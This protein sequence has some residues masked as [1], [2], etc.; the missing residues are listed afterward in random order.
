MMLSCKIIVFKLTLQTTN[1][2]FVE[3]DFFLQIVNI[4]T[5]AGIELMEC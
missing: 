3:F 4:F 1:N 5:V 2:F